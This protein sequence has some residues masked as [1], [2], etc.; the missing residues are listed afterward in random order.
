MKILVVDCSGGLK[1]MLIAKDKVY[2]FFSDEKRQSAVLLAEI[3]KL[4][5]QAN[6]NLQNLDAIAVGVGPG[7]FTGIRVAISTV[8]G[9]AIGAGCKVL[10]FDAFDA[11]KVDREQKNFGIVLDGFGEN[12]YYYFKRFGREFKGCANEQ[13]MLPLA[14]N[15][16]VYSSS[17]D[18]VNSIT[19]F[20]VSLAEYD[21]T[22]VILR[23]ANAGEFVQTNQI[24]PQYL[25]A[26]QAE[27]ERQKKLSGSSN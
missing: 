9:L 23:K 14:T 2:K 27:L 18:V 20:A 3:E 26:S 5:G 17:K 4:L 12:Y 22:E 16:N 15:A 6:I 8:K 1:I 21:P 24:V 13:K 25:R 11:V 19:Q 7:S 10:T